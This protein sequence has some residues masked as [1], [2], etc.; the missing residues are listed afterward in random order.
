MKKSILSLTFLLILSLYPTRSN[1]QS[2]T[3]ELFEGLAE[4]ELGSIVSANGIIN[5]QQYLSTTI[6]NARNMNVQ[7]RIEVDWRKNF[8]SDRKFVALALTSPFV[9]KQDILR[10]TNLDIGSDRYQ[11]ET[12]DY[13]D[14]VLDELRKLGKLVGEV[15]VN[16][17]LIL[18]DG[19]EFSSGEKRIG[20]L[21][22]AS[23]LSII[24]PAIGSSWDEGNIPMQWNSISGASDYLVRCNTKK[25]DEDNEEGLKSGEPLLWDVSVK[26]SF[27]NLLANNNI[28]DIPININLWDLFAGSRVPTPGSEIVLQVVGVVPS[29]S[30]DTKIESPIVNFYLND[31]QDQRSPQ[32]TRRF[33]ASMREYVPNSNLT[34]Q[35]QEDL[36][37]FLDLVEKGQVNYNGVRDSNGNI[38]LGREVQRILRYLQDNPGMIVSIKKK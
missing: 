32:Q 7:I 27:P 24:M 12:S 35:E 6:N 8:N 28:A 23:T 20:L 10:I 16:A 33:V 4:L 31:P 25:P 30:V 34:V 11:L 37:E 29:T 21:N 13:D 14:D 36:M 26:N 19:R 38:I 17:F 3:L 15:Y 1:A 22:P 5:T 2:I 18:D 9:V